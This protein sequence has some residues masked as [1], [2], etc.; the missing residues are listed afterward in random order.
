VIPGLF[1]VGTDTGVGKTYISAAIARAMTGE[2]RRVGVLKPVATG[3]TPATGDVFPS[4][5]AGG[6][7]GA[8]PPGLP[9]PSTPHPTLPRKE[10][11]L[12]KETSNDQ[13]EAHWHV[14]DAAHL[15]QAIGGAATTAE[16]CPIAYEE[17]LAPPV[18]ARR[19]GGPLDADRVFDATA[20]AI[21][22]WQAGRGAEVMVV[23]GVGG[24]LCPLAEGITVADLAVR[25]DYP[26]VVVARRGLG[27]LNHTLLTVEAALMRSLRVA[28]VVLN[29]AEPTADPV[30]EATNP[31]ELARRLGPV[32]VRAEI[33][34]GAD[35][36]SMAVVMEGLGWYN[37]ASA[38]RLPFRP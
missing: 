9:T 37:R 38:P 36:A 28:G 19:A 30:A 5:L 20:T 31:A 33:P 23:E 25:L 35:E 22:H 27:T 8:G 16:V 15:I 11:G 6:G 32:P 34:H 18:A 1:V 14:D 7:R 10:G 4:P 24:L 2:G 13:E 17:P 12:P 26:L 3:A 21:E 29:G